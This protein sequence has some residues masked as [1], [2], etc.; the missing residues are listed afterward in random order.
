[1][2]KFSF[3]FTICFFLL[4]CSW[5][6]CCGQKEK[7]A[8]KQVIQISDK[9]LQEKDIAIYKTEEIRGKERKS[10]SLDFSGFEKPGSLE[11][12]TQYFHFPPL[13]Q[14][15][16]GTCWCFSTTS[17][18]ESEM[19]RLGKDEV[20]LSEIYTVY[21]EFV[22]K[23]RRFIKEKGNSFF[24]H[25]SEHNAVPARMKQY[26]AVRASDYSGLL[27]G[28]TEHDHDQVFQE[29]R[30][31]LQFCKENSYWDEEKAVSYVKSILNK[32]LGKPPETIEVN[33]K[34]MTPKE[35]LENVLKLPLDDYLCFMSFKY[36]PFYTKGEFR[37]PDNW[38][39][40]EDYHNLP[41]ED[42][43]KAIV[44]SL[45]KG[46]TV[47]I[48]GDISEPG[49]NGENDM[50]VVPTFDL[51]QKLIDQESREFRFNNR[52]SSD[53]HAIHIVG[54]KEGDG[55][56][57]FLVKDSGSSAYK[58]HFK[59]YYFYRDDYIRL[60]ML[61]FMVHKDTVADLLEKFK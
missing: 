21:W 25:G 4:L 48:G 8:E 55:H 1:M 16:T 39:H 24:G 43:Y 58:G 45:K 44:S 47:A 13:R 22:E 60:K 54:Y 10:L 36:L 29:I 34:T 57:W 12:F 46:Y 52:T 6:I 18:L 5:F 49:I 2:K 42:F 53:D 37:A 14:N 3:I 41:L 7:A 17:F 30:N 23:A 40:S 28:Q 56:T 11:E 19:K 51:P 59:G 61:T 33:G 50:A 32:Y 15:K 26:G 27:P 20:K 9:E 35:Y 38:W 31:Y